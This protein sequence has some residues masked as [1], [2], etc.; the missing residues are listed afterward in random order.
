MRMSAPDTMR[1]TALTDMITRLSGR[2]LY[3]LLQAGTG[4][5]R[6]SE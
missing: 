1:A 6:V 4:S 5:P 2:S 3:A